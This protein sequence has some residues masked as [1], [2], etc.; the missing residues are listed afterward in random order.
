LELNSDEGSE[1]SN[2]DH[3]GT[4]VFSHCGNA[5]KYTDQQGISAQLKNIV[6]SYDD[7]NLQGFI[8][9]WPFYRI[10]GEPVVSKEEAIAIAVNASESYS[11]TITNADGVSETVSGFKIKSIGEPSLCYLNAME[12]EFAR[13]G[14]PFVLFPEWY[15]P[16]GFEGQ[17]PGGVSGVT[18]RVWAD[19]GEVSSMGNLK[20]PLPG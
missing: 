17:Y 12:A 19:T 14:D 8:N 5:K 15:V 18:V 20:A 11:Y 4:V 3:F 6:L 10:G 13:G 16:L 9:N 1:S 7:G 2:G